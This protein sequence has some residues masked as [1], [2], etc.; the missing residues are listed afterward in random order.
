V[1]TPS[2]L[3]ADLLSAAKAQLRM[4]LKVST[5]CPVSQRRPVELLMQSTA[6]SSQTCL[7]SMLQR[8]P[9]ELLMQSAAVNVQM[10][11]MSTPFVSTLCPCSAH[12]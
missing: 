3:S 8:P 10:C 6:V 12:L 11:L 9:V 7:M 1:Q 5:Y 4:I 2:G